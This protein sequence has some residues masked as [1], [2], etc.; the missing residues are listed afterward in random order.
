M[1]DNSVFLHRAKQLE[2]ARDLVAGDADYGSAAA[3]LAVHTAIALNDAL[4]LKLTGRRP[5]LSDHAKA[6][7]QTK[8]ACSE[9]KLGHGGVAHL[10]TLLSKKTLISYG[11]EITSPELAASLGVAS[12]RFQEWAYS[13]LIKVGRKS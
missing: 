3:L 6:A 13:I 5:R 1:A 8:A 4:L 2:S 9:R 11:D 12:S 7:D 10:Q